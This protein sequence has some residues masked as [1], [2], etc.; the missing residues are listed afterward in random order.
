MQQIETM[1]KAWHEDLSCIDDQIFVEAIAKIRR[2][3]DFFPT[4][5]TVLKESEEIREQQAI[6]NYNSQLPKTPSFKSDQEIEYSKKKVK[7]ILSSLR[8]SCNMSHS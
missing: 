3:K 5:A 1:A 8:E 4:I 6:H 2:T 7:E